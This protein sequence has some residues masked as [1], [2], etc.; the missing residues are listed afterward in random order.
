MELDSPEV[1]NGG[2]RVTWLRTA[3]LV[4]AASAC[5]SDA[6][7]CLALPCPIP[8]AVRLTVQDGATGSPIANARNASTIHVT[9]ESRRYIWLFAMYAAAT[10]VTP[11]NIPP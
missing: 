10:A 1:R 9:S 7:V 8:T 5:G 11:I 2:R 3:V 6:T 4:L